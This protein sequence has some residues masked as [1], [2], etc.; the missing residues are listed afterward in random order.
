MES[1]VS[2]SS[3]KKEVREVS[4]KLDIVIM[5]QERLNRFIM[6][7]EKVVKRPSKLPPLPIKT[8]RELT[9][10]EQFLS[11]E[12]NLSATVSMHIYNV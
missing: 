1:Q 5:N 11:E 2:L 3:L 9:E 6:P 4:S 8:E 7:T 12:N 10:M